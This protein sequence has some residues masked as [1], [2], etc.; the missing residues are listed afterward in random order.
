MGDVISSRTKIK[1]INA[2]NETILQRLAEPFSA[3][4]WTVGGE[5]LTSALNLAWRYLLQNH[6]HDN[7]CGAGIDQMEKDMMYRFDQSIII[8][9]GVM[10]R[11]LS[12]IQKRINNKDIDINESVIT[13]FN[14]SP[15]PRSEVVTLSID[16]PEKSKY[17]G[18]SIRDNEG[19]ALPVA[20]I[21]REPYGTLVR[22]LEDISL[23][24]RS[25]RI[26]LHTLFDA[27]P[28]F[29]YKTY[30][31]NREEKDQEKLSVLKGNKQSIA[32]MENEYLKVQIKNDG[33][34]DILDKRS[35]HEYKNQHYFEESGESG[36][37][38]IHMAPEQD[39]IITTAG[40]KAIIE[41]VETSDLLIRYRIKHVLSVP[42]GLQGREGN[43]HRSD[44]RKDLNIESLITLRKEQKWI[45]VETKVDNQVEQHRLRV[46]FPTN[47]RAQVSAAEAAF[48]VIERQIERGPESLYYDKPNP[49]YPMHRFVDMSDGRIGLAILNDGMREYEAVDNE[50][51]TLC[52]TLLRGFTAMQSPVIDQMDVYPWMKLSQS[53]GINEWRYAIMPHPGNWQKGS[54]Y[55]E[56]EKFTLP[57][58]TAQAGKG[59]GDLPK[60]LSFVEVLPAE[61]VLSTMKK[62]E[63]RDTLVLRLFNPTATMIP[64]QIKLH[65]AIKSAW[66]TNMNEERR[67]ELNVED[68]TVAMSFAPKKIIT[69]EVEL[70]G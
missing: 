55:K 47:L 58:E 26:M 1:R 13:V 43:Y 4:G 6:P 62:C 59:G 57:L 49:Q 67:K 2:Q 7:I 33:S 18:F 23:Q 38:W 66:L 34:L 61:I 21:N 42:D 10:R 56:A 30:R 50:E 28:A 60:Q 22:N 27:V 45:D 64:A 25:E 65:S 52:I 11:G 8:S 12:A 29:G 36:H 14:P 20:E 70:A 46:C 19:N 17:K 39:E 53:L 31:I 40:K 15:F 24:L 69:V 48:D 3:I 9:Q 54:V 51:R 68:K 32:T 37:A 63:H 5:Y 41:H 44:K 16:L 35:A